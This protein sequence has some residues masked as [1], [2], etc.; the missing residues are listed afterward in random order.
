MRGWDL[1]PSTA[2]RAL[3]VDHLH[4]NFS[5]PS[6][7]GIYARGT[8]R[9]QIRD[10]SLVLTHV[11]IP[12]HDAGRLASDGSDA[13][14]RGTTGDLGFGKPSVQAEGASTFLAHSLSNFAYPIASAGRHMMGPAPV[15]TTYK[16]G[17][18]TC[19]P[20]TPYSA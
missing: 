7:R 16:G 3:A 12:G 1:L 20:P 15:T 14:E 9:L 17:L 19:E 4:S 13:T 5:S 6:V 11:H 10:L 8:L 2:V 18:V